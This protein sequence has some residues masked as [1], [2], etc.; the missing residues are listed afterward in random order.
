MLDL[1]ETLKKLAA[2][3]SPS[4]FETPVAEAITDLAAPYADEIKTDALGNLIVYRKATEQEGYTPKKVMLSAHMDSIGMI[5]TNIDDKGFLRFAGLG[6]LNPAVLLNIPVIFANGT[7][8]VIS[9]D[10]NVELKDLKLQN[11]YMDIGANT[12]EEAQKNV[13]IGDT[14]VYATETYK[15]GE[16]S[17]VS[18]YHDDRIACVVML[19]A[20]Q[21]IKE[22][23]NDIYFV[24]STQEELGTRGAKTAA[25]LIEPEIG[26]A[27]DVTGT[28]DTP[29]LKAPMECS[30][31][32]GAAIKI[33][34]SSLVCSPK[35]VSALEETAKQHEIMYQFEV[36]EHGGT[37][38]GA[39]QLARAG[40]YAGAVSIPT[41][42]I[43]SP[44]EMA[45]ENDIKAA[46][47][48][49]GIFAAS[50]INI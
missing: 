4:G 20:L 45:D 39:I 3:H 30:L 49:V 16:T 11:L 6:V 27:V 24:F 15:M 17:I 8:G 7:R 47:A 33:M 29:N 10:G 22:T 2:I 14:A 34:D 48:L 12:K 26:L 46:A 43:H 41:R 21:S 40:A 18:P 23:K 1:F 44:Q 50:K 9:K 42:Y 36:L 25:F 38:A 5:V 32:K 19:M 35:I 37:D 31:G 28:G 13:K